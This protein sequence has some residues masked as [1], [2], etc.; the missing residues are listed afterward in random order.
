MKSLLGLTTNPN[1][2]EVIIGEGPIDLKRRKSKKESYRGD[3][4]T[5]HRTCCQHDSRGGRKGLS[6][7]K[8]KVKETGVLCPRPRG[9]RGGSGW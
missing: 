7:Q 3:R 2:V 9:L 1:V 4:L 5:P 6:M 8:S